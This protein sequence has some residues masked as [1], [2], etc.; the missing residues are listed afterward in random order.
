MSDEKD[1]EFF[2]LRREGKTY[3]S[4]V[5]PSM[6]GPKEHVRFV[7]MVISN[8]DSVLMGE[9]EGA[10]CLR[11]DGN[12]RKTQIVA[13]ISQDDKRVR[14]LS[15]QT[16]KTRNN[17]AMGQHF[18]TTEK[19]EFTFRPGEFEKLLRFLKSI[20]FLD[21]SNEERFQIEDISSES[22]PKAIIDASDKGI[23]QN[24]KKMRGQEREELFASLSGS[25]S[26][27]EINILLGRKSGLSEFRSQISACVWNE[28]KWQDFFEREQWVFGYGLD[29][30]IMRRFDREAS[31]GQSGTDNQNRPIVDFLMNFSEYSVL[32]EIKR[33]DTPIFKSTKKGRAGT[34]EFSAEFVSAISQLLEQQAEWQIASASGQHFDKTGKRRL[35][36]RTRKPKTILVIGSKNEF[37]KSGIERDE[38]TMLDTFELFRREC[39]S[40]DIITFDELFERAQY[41]AQ[42]EKN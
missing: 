37:S 34:W 26:T 12:V 31:V 1:F 4:K 16:F 22:G 24:L 14:R 13:L 15:L 2:R 8:T 23:L 39:G 19:N 32:V 25:L 5:F 41:I 7:N 42:K 10:L 29:Y 18:T 20:E 21:V 28:T 40:V 9:L 35:E 6:I 33:P 27:E 36:T 38:E 3:L 11:V 17:Q 30:R